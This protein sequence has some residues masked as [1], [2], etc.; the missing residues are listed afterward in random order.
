MDTLILTLTNDTSKN[1]IFVQSTST[2][3]C[4]SYSPRSASQQLKA[5]LKA[6]LQKKYIIEIL[7]RN[8][9]QNILQQKSTFSTL[10]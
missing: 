9:Q 10:L 1:N 7:L 2:W 3:A 8:S 6:F 5:L 4:F